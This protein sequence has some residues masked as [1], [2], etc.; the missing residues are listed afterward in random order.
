M[1]FDESINACKNIDGWKFVT[2]I[3]AFPTNHYRMNIQWM[4]STLKLGAYYI[5]IKTQ[6]IG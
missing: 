5:I 3:P 1:T 4:L 2:S 6:I